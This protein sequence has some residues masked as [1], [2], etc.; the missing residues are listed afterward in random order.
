MR[1]DVLRRLSSKEDFPDLATVVGLLADVEK[2]DEAASKRVAELRKE[3]S[4]Y[5][6]HPQ[7]SL[8]MW[9]DV[10]AEIDQHSVRSFE[11]KEEHL[12]RMTEEYIRPLSLYRQSVIKTLKGT[13]LKN[14]AT[15]Q[16]NAIT[17]HADRVIARVTLYLTPEKESS[18]APEPLLSGFL[19]DHMW[20]WM[21]R[22]EGG[23]AEVSQRV[24]TFCS[25]LTEIERD[26]SRDGSSRC[27]IIGVI[28]AP[29]PT[30]WTTGRLLCLKTFGAILD[31][32][33][34]T[35]RQK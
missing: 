17:K 11:E 7:Q 28:F 33:A 9:A 13:W 24:I 21:T 25:V 14:G 27:W 31:S 6:V 4:S 29:G 3:I 2:G 5:E 16:D 35:R 34:L 19:M 22:T 15:A 32:L 10:M 30:S 23:I 26:R 12:E 20:N 8:W 18:T 1:C